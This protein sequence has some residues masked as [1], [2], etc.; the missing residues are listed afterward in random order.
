MCVCVF[1]IHVFKNCCREMFL[2]IQN[3]IWIF[4]YVACLI[5][6]ISVFFPSWKIV[7]K[8][9]RHLLDTWPICRDLK[10]CLITISIAVST[11]SG[12]IG[13]IP[14][15][16]IASR[17][18]VDWSSFFL[19]FVEL[20]LDSSL[21]ASS[22]NAFFPQHLSRHLARYLL[23]PLSVKNYWGSINRFYAI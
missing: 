2:R 10:L 22:V 7:F 18:L 8:K 15:P 11:A 20:S 6:F 19:A 3:V 13:K 9:Y 12:L 23:T 21:I 14:R 1:R 5:A 4:G 17:Q 16:S